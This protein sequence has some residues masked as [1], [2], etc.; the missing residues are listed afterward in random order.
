MLLYMRNESL[1]RH[2]LKPEDL[3]VIFDHTERR[4]RFASSEG[5]PISRGDDGFYHVSAEEW[6]SVKMEVGVTML[7][8]WA[9]SVTPV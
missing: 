1:R 7:T 3:T 4:R 5:R 9:G 6:E 2:G 8:S